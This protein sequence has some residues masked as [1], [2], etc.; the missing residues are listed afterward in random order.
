[1]GCP[2][3]PLDIWRWMPTSRFLLAP[4]LDCRP[5]SAS[6]FGQRCL[7][8]DVSDRR[9]EIGLEDRLA[10]HSV[11]GMG[12]ADQVAL[13]RADGNSWIVGEERLAEAERHQRQRQSRVGLLF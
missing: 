2:V 10:D 1:M 13:L 9:A 11:I 4:S 3:K 6:I 8:G 5:V 12:L 7:L